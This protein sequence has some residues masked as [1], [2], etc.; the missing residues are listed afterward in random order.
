M[1][2][3]MAS[4]QSVDTCEQISQLRRSRDPE[5][6]E[7]ANTLRIIGWKE[8]MPFAGAFDS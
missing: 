6:Y 7:P 2:F 5:L 4:R 1:L 3:G 8:S